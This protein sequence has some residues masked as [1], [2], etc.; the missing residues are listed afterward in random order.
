MENIITL[1]DL[2]NL[3]LKINKWENPL[4]EIKEYINLLLLLINKRAYLIIKVNEDATDISLSKLPSYTHIYVDG[5]LRTDLTTFNQIAG[6]EVLVIL[7]DSSYAEFTIDL[8]ISEISIN[9]LHK[10]GPSFNDLNS[11][12][13]K[14]PERNNFYKVYLQN[15]D[16]I[17]AD[18]FRFTASPSFGTPSDIIYHKHI[19]LDDINIWLSRKNGTQHNRENV[20]FIL[21][22][23]NEIINTFIINNYIGDYCLSGIALENSDINLI[24]EH[25]N[26]SV[27]DNIGVLNKLF[28]KD[29]IKITAALRTKNLY[30]EKDLKYYIE[31]GYNKNQLS[32]YHKPDN[33]YTHA[34]CT[35]DSFKGN[36]VSNNL[37]IDDTYN[38][39]I[40]GELDGFE[41]LISTLLT[42]E[43]TSTKITEIKKIDS[44]KLKK[45]YIGPNVNHIYDEGIINVEAIYF[46]N[47]DQF[48]SILC[49]GGKPFRRSNSVI[50]INNEQLKNIT[51]ENVENAPIL[52]GIYGIE[53]IELKNV[54]NLTTG[55]LVSVDT[56]KLTIKQFQAPLSRADSFSISNSF[57]TVN[58]EYLGMNT[59]DQG[60]NKL[61]VPTGATGFEEGAWLDVLLNPDICGFTI[62]YSDELAAELNSQTT[63]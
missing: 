39:T 6:K 63:T 21:Y 3:P 2:N 45:L 30:L 38:I 26:Y 62:E 14:K 19:F 42:I 23:K 5:E 47:I 54:N 7:K 48:M 10:L 40:I 51:I 1:K 61:I 20:Q 27:F 41:I 55:S 59:K 4:I 46:N 43:I 9:N 56:N 11:I 58:D 31:N 34:Y 33:I 12:Y 50:Y 53:T 17:S 52:D 22:E 32:Y 25:D 16:V 44:T 13:Y 60:I 36:R 24:V 49:N 8:P 28:I 57:S 18:L 37:I 15:I 29:G 35:L